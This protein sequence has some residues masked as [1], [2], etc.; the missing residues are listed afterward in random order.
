[1]TRIRD[2]F[3]LH[4]SGVRCGTQISKIKESLFIRTVRVLIC[5]M[6]GAALRCKGPVVLRKV[7]K[8]NCERHGT[9]CEHVDD[10]EGGKLHLRRHTDAHML[11]LMGFSIFSL[12]YFPG[13]FQLRQYD[14]QVSTSYTKTFYCPTMC[15]GSTCFYSCT[16]HFV[17]TSS[18]SRGLI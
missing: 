14:R 10:F 7:Y 8:A 11:I 5:V 3:W 6:H 1:M 16:L 17:C 18:D 4:E 15:C 13:H 9:H 2:N 12:N